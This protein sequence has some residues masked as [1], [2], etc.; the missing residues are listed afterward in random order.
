MVWSQWKK[1]L[2]NKGIKADCGF[3]TIDSRYCHGFVLKEEGIYIK[4]IM[5]RFSPIYSDDNDNMQ[6]L[7]LLITNSHSLEFNLNV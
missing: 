5:E 4:I 2:P 7:K 1:S 6:S 3:S